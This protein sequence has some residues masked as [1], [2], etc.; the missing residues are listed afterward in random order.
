MDQK[1]NL[2]INE[3]IE[4][5]VEFLK[6][7]Q[8]ENGSISINND[9]RWEVW[10]T[11]NSFL[12]VHSIVG[13]HKKFLEN[14]ISFISK[15]RKEDGSFYYTNSSKKDDYCM[16][17]TALSIKALGISKKDVE[18]G[19]QFILNKQNSDGSWEIGIKRIIKYRNWPSITGF[20]LN[21]LLNLEI[22]SDQISKGI[23]FI[24]EKQ[25]EDGSWG[26]KWIYYDTPYYPTHVILSA[27]KLYGYEKEK[28]FKKVV[29]FIKKNQN[30]NGSWG[31]NRYDKPAPSLDLR[32]ALALNSLLTSPDKTD[33]PSIK[34]GIKWLVNT[35]KTDGH[36]DGGFF[37]NWPGKKEDIYTT[38]LAIS[39]L[40]KYEILQII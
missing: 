4:K 21:T 12:A 5:A 29:N 8:N 16:E 36:W 9:K 35:Q 19:I 34:R 23:K 22:S 11:V 37:V 31:K 25:K 6:N 7:N 24:F 33:L 1:S 27:L 3:S 2:D 39:A 40:K 13:N 28:I 18:K 32:T 17:A 30:N 26:S 14:A 38:S 10:E 20:V 15:S